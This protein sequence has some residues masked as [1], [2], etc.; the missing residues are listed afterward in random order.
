MEFST[1]WKLQ[2]RLC[3]MR[4]EWFKI[5]CK[6]GSKIIYVSQFARW[7]LS[8]NSFKMV[9][10]WI[11]YSVD[12]V[13]P[14]MKNSPDCHAKMSKI[15]YNVFCEKYRKS[16][17]WPE[18]HAGGRFIPCLRQ[19]CTFDRGYMIILCYKSLF[20][21]KNMTYKNMRLKVSKNK[22]G[23]SCAKLSTA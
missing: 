15:T 17:F 14:R 16:R 18:F 3:T 10:N 7:I 19:S 22:L 6:S 21:Y 23:L 12:L 1:L 2:C 8:C 11:L 13:C 9:C 5:F 4:K 20:F